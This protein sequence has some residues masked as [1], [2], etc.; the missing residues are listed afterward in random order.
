MNCNLFKSKL[1][2][3]CCFY[4]DESLNMD[5]YKFQ[6]APNYFETIGVNILINLYLN[7]E[8]VYL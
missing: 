4:L 3:Y 1:D 5:N 2:Y 7:M 6:K 8:G